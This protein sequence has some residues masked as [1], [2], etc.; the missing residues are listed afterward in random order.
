MASVS[1][2]LPPS[3]VAANETCPESLMEGL[4]PMLT[5]RLRF[6]AMVFRSPFALTRYRPGIVLNP[7]GAGRPARNAMPPRRLIAAHPKLDE[8]N[9]SSTLSATL[10]KANL[11]AG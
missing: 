3:S 8:S 6:C 10:V 2:F 5:Y 4:K 1:G 9:P 7:S 11:G